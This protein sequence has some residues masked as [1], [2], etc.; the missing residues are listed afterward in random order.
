MPPRILGAGAA[1]LLASGLCSAQVLTVRPLNDT[2]FAKCG[3]ETSNDIGCSYLDTDPL[4]FPR[5]DGQ[6]GR[7]PKEAAA[8]GTE[9]LART[10][11]AKV[12]T[13]T[14]PGFDFSKV[15]VNGTLQNG[16]LS[17]QAGVLGTTATS[18]A[19][20]KDNVTGLI[21]LLKSPTGN[22]HRLNTS[23]YNW[24]SADGNVN[25]GVS[26]A[27]GVA[28]GTQCYNSTYCDT[29]SY[30][31]YINALNTTVGWCGE[32]T[33]SDWRL[34]TRLELLS[35]VDSYSPM[36][37]V[38]SGT[39][40]DNASTVTV[41]D[42]HLLD[43][44][45]MVDGIGI[46]SGARIASISGNVVTLTAA[47]T[48]AVSGDLTFKREAAVDIVFFPNMRSGYYWARETFAENPSEA[49]FVNFGFGTDGTSPK[50]DKMHVILVRP[51]P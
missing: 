48:A 31:T 7:S 10:A 47:N 17:A 11:L 15:L 43:A 50:G 16:A 28:S 2:G 42:A 36:L 30:I 46:A 33:K 19:C 25:G 1:L 21:W 45:M 35:I 18:W 3:N 4:G 14:S 44:R 41:A 40:A 34:P 22:D 27:Q 12:G 26:G 49:R 5:Q 37:V 38:T 8:G 13:S 39:G 20:T 51:S 24:K 32:G 9:V 6:F 29:E 23:T